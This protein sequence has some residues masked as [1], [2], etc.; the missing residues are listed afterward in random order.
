M[1]DFARIGENGGEGTRILGGDTLRLDIPNV[2]EYTPSEKLRLEQE[3]L[4]F[5]VSHNM[6]ELYS[7]TD[8]LRAQNVVPGTEL[9]KY[10][11]RDVAV[12]G[13]IVAGRR[14]MTKSGEWMLFLTLQDAKSL[15]EVVLFPETYKASEELLADGGYGPYIVHGHVQVSGKGRGVRCAVTR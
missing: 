10:A 7:D 9:P 12:A 2:G 8:R 5:T 6:M 1:G 13:V 15:I 11:E 14:H 4:G 3:V